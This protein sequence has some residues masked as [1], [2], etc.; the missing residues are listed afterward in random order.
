MIEVTEVDT[1][2]D[3]TTANEMMANGWILLDAKVQEGGIVMF[4]LG[5]KPPCLPCDGSGRILETIVDEGKVAWQY[6]K[7]PQCTD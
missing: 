6:V 4:A 3:P 1:T 5:K 2:I 7:C